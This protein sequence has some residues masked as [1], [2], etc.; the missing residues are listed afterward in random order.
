[1]SDIESIS[2]MILVID[3]EG[4]LLKLAR[5]RL[6]ANGYDVTTAQNGDYAL[7]II[8]K[9]KI[10]AVLLDI[11]MPG[12]DGYSA[13][14]QIRQFNKDLII[15]AQTAFAMTGD[16]EKAIAAGCNDHLSKPFR[17]EE[18]RRVMQQY[19]GK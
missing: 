18:L 15:I 13:T 12:M 7:K 4:D 5:S 3:D 11:L 8:N 10:S 1:M 14:R 2:K 17:I 19:I 9:E 16:R 6:E